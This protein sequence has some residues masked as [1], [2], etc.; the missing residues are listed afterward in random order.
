MT[1]MTSRYE[2]RA[3]EPAVA[4][5]LRERDD[6]GHQPRIVTDDDGGSPLR[7]CLRPSCPGEQIALVSYAPLRRW[8]DETGAQPGPYDEVGPVFIHPQPCDGPA[9]AGIPTELMGATRVFRGYDADGSIVG[10]RLV[11][12]SEQPERVLEEIFDDPAV[13]LVHVR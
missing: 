9:D 6:A 3:I 4:A 11:P 12:S 8:A 13:A 7:C 10:G 1:T 2:I 5:A